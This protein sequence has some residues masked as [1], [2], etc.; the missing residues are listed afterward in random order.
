MSLALNKEWTKV[1][2]QFSIQISSI[3]FFFFLL[4]FK[5]KFYPHEDETFS[6]IVRFV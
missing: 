1:C 4:M 2:T 3:T 5:P 6:F